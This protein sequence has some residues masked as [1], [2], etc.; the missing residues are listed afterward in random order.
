MAHNEPEKKGYPYEA[1]PLCGPSP[2]GH[3]KSA[4]E[5]AVEVC[6]CS[7]SLA[8]RAEVERYKAALE[9]ISRARADRLD[10][11]LDIAIIER[12]SRIAREALSP[13]SKP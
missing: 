13:R 6:G 8:L 12:A 11:A 5:Q 3:P 9:R 4:T 2:K 7:E 1:S 10:H